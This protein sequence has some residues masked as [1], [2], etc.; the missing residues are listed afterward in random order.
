MEETLVLSHII[1][2]GDDNDSRFLAFTCGA[3]IVREIQIR[4]FGLYIRIVCVY[5]FY[6]S[7]LSNG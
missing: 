1:H 7:S 2:D 3:T 4:Q 6:A 5:S